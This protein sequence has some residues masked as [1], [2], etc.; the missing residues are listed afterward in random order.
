MSAP[1]NKCEETPENE[2]QSSPSIAATCIAISILIIVC[3][4]AYWVLLGHEK[5]SELTE[6]QTTG[7]ASECSNTL[8]RLYGASETEFFNGTCYG[9][10]KTEDCTEVY[11]PRWENWI[12]ECI[13]TDWFELTFEFS[14]PLY[15]RPETNN[16]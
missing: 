11:N 7:Q 13:Y 16:E 1:L 15:E 5:H 3:V 6:D 2:D 10:F 14:A 8:R 4:G 9:K 12:T